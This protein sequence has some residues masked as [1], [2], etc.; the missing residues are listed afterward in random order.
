[1]SELS[2]RLQYLALGLPEMNGGGRYAV[3]L[4]WLTDVLPADLQVNS[5]GF[6]DDIEKVATL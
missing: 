5:F 6:S 3:I 2:S 1:M 4:Q